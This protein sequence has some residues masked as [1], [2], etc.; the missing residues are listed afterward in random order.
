M[1]E[2]SRTRGGVRYAQLCPSRAMHRS[3]Q[4]RSAPFSL[5]RYPPSGMQL[6]GL[7]FAV[8]RTLASSVKRGLK[9]S[10]AGTHRHSLLLGDERC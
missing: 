2:H 7:A 6:A 10:N 4:A 9:P 5:D 8:T 1:T 3:R